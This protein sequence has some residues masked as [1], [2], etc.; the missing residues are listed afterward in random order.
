V[1]VDRRAADGQSAGDITGMSH[2]VESAVKLGLG[3]DEAHTDL[4]KS[5]LG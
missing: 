4:K 3:A 2:Y 5:V 1:L